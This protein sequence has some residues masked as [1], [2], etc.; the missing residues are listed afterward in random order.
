MTRKRTVRTNTCMTSAFWLFLAV[1]AV[2]TALNAPVIAQNPVPLT[3]QP[4]VPDAIAPGGAGFTLTVNGTGFVTSSVVNWSGSPRA[5]TFV[6]SSKLTATILASDIATASTAAVT[7]VSPGPGAISN[8]QFFS[9]AVAE[10]SVSFLPAVTYDSGGYIAQSIR[11]AD[12]N[13]DGKP[14]IVVANWW[15]TNNIGDVSV[16]IGNGDGTF[17]P[18]VT[19]ETGGAPNYS[20][21][22][23][24][25]NGDGKLDLIVSSCA[26]SASLCGSGE[27][28][29]SVL[30]GNGDGTFRYA[31]SYGSGAAVGA[32]VAVADVNGDGKLDLI[33]TNYQGESNGDG[34][35]AVLLGK[36][37]GT[38]Q[39]PV[40]YDSGAPGANAVTVAD[41]NG[42]GMLDL[43]VANGCFSNCTGGQESLTVLS[44]LPGNGDGT[45]RPA[46]I[47][48]TGAKTSGWISAADINGD[49]VLDAVLSSLNLGS[50]SG[51]VSILLGA[52]GGTFEPAVTYDSGGYA[53]PELAL[54]DLR[55]DGLLD[56]VVENCG[57]V[58]GCGT[59]VIGVL[60]GRGDGTFNPLVPFSSGAYNATSIAVADLNGDGRPDLVAANQCAPN[61]CTTGSLAV[62]L[63]SSGSTHC[64]DKCSTSTTLVSSPNPS[65]SGQSITFTATVTSTGGNPPN[66]E[67]VTFHNGLNVLGTSTLTGGVAAL[68]TS[69]L[70]SGMHT[71]SAAYLGDANFTASTS[72][73]LQQAV[74]TTS[75]SPTSIALASSLNPSIYGQSVTWSATVTTSGK[76]TP[77]GK[78]NFNWGSYSLGTATLNS[79]GVATLTRSNLS[80][81]SYPQ[82][83]VYTG[84]AN[85]GPSASPILNQTVTQTTSAATLTSSPNPST[86]GQAVT[87][88]ATIT[89][90]TTTP[91]G[92]VTFSAGKTTLGT[93]ELSKGKATFTTST[94]AVGSDTVTVTYPWNSDISG[95][96]AS[97]LQTVTASTGT[98]AA[99]LTWLAVPPQSETFTATVTSSKA[100]PTGTV[101]FTAGR[102]GQVVS[103]G[104]AL[105]V[106]ALPSLT[107]S[108]WTGWRR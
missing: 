6:S 66:G 49:G 101:T 85:N 13:G 43:L 52:G 91:T 79:S 31:L 72:P 104:P 10:T 86:Q 37:D 75:Q 46:A 39:S 8:T 99:T 78:V 96:S 23:A 56:I 81:D 9:I 69:K 26:A 70:G 27:G 20:L 36:G 62:L 25:V 1:F 21:V 54:A 40:L 47:Y 107:P 89:S 44:V 3:N 7:V 82:F 32:H 64:A 68:T 48:M 41:V 106:N 58:G 94:L 35:V 67:T 87:F 73:V 71:I 65:I 29:V 53:A 92:P 59:G 4:L 14:D 98:T 33:V 12:L 16:L 97:V 24:D 76:T 15:D 51:I 55:A 5:T 102:V 50:A 93:V 28:V 105:A 30:L 19:Y 38:F 60:P 80:A 42:D 61:G 108:W 45:F 34:T 88:T 90:P 83:A 95:S 57:P 103:A 17:Q 63:N 11:I 2:L 74:D 18:A 77:T 22:V 84:D 100:V